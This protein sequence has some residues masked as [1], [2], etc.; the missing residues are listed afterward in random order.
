MAGAGACHSDLAVFQNFSEGDP[1]AQKPPFILGHESSGWVEE[2]GPGVN[3]FTKGDAYLIY[4]PIRLS[5]LQGLLPRARHVL[6]ER[7][8]S[9]LRRYWFGPRRWHGGV[10]FRSGKEPRGTW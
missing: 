2:F 1:G 10:R 9:A 4:G 3:G 8:R 5:A 6:R 7:R